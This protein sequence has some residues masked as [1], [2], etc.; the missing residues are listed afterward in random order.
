MKYQSTSLKEFLDLLNRSPDLG[1][2]WRQV[3][4]TLWPFVEDLT[5]EKTLEINHE[6]K[7]VRFKP[8]PADLARQIEEW[9]IATQR[10]LNS[11]DRQELSKER[12]SKLFV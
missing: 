11:H 10:E 5:E 12:A 8:T 2:G 9:R 6:L 4:E 1:D 3:S 7:R